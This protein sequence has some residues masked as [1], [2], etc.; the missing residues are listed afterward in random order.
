MAPLEAILIVGE[1][2]SFQRLIVQV[3]NTRATSCLHLLH[4]H[5]LSLLVRKEIVEGAL[6]GLCLAVFSSLVSIDPGAPPQ[7]VF[8]TAIEALEQ[9]Q[10]SFVQ[11]KRSEDDQAQV[12][13]EPWIK[14]SPSL[15]IMVSSNRIKLLASL[16]CIDRIEEDLLVG[17]GPGAHDQVGEAHDIDCLQL[18]S[19]Q[20]LV[21]DRHA[22][23]GVS[24]P[25]HDS[26]ILNHHAYERY[27]KQYRKLR[28]KKEGHG[29]KKEDLCI[30]VLQ[31]KVGARV[32]LLVPKYCLLAGLR[33][34]ERRTAA[35]LLVISPF[36]IWYDVGDAYL[37]RWEDHEIPHG[38]YD[39]VPNVRVPGQIM[40]CVYALIEP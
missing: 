8:L 34:F 29:D 19:V 6:A 5:A 24:D 9:S 39:V 18:S 31:V 25:Q 4:Q 2:D 12:E 16:N 22:T 26:R 37:D 15:P 35:F 3:L 28:S 27:W 11:Q 10:D 17:V 33:R 20:L 32:E 36:E 1:H 40:V 38:H 21:V 14:L 13:D 23:D 30:L 7:V